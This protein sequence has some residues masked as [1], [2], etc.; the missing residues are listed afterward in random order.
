MTVA[1]FNTYP[2]NVFVAHKTPVI[3]HQSTFISQ[4]ST[5]NSHQSTNPYVTIYW[6]NQLNIYN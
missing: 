4:Q 2:K 3:S 6:R 5:V 1:F